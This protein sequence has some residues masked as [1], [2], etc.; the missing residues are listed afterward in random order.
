MLAHWRATQTARLDDV[1][2]A[3][4]PNADRLVKDDF[5]AFLMAASLDRRGKA[6]HIWNVPWKLLQ[7]WG[8]LDP[9]IIRTMDAAELALDPIIKSAPSTTSRTD[10]AKTVISVAAVVEDVGAGD[11]H[12]LL[13]GSVQEIII[14]LKRIYGVGDGIARMIVIQ[15]LL[16]FG[17]NVAPYDGLLPKLDEL[18]RRVFE[19][20]GLVTSAVDDQVAR[21]LNGYSSVEIAMVDQVAWAVGQ[22]HCFP[23]AP[24]CS[25]CILTNACRRVGV[26]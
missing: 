24:A 22:T 25:S 10:L 20:T 26:L 5:F 11:P 4:D 13:A 2:F 19:R 3:A 1:P 9:K 8:H 14:R 7:K 12:R 21:A 23:Q 6:V 18:V 16:F 17:L 15:R